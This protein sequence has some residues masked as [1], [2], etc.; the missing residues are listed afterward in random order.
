M[1]AGSVVFT[2]IG[3]CGLYFIVG[4]AF[5]ILVAREILRGPL[6]R[7]NPFVANGHGSPASLGSATW[8]RPWYAL[9]TVMVAMF[10]I[11]DGWN[12]GAGILHHLIARSGC[13]ARRGDRGARPRLELE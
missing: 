6:V 12:L 2:L 5:L 9:M 7:H 8:L 3:F 4:V 10:L 13:R 1:H 11:L